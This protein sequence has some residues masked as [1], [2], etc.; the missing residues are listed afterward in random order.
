MVAG[1]SIRERILQAD[2]STR[3][4]IGIFKVAGVSIRERILQDSIPA[5]KEPAKMS[6]GYRSERG[7]CKSITGWSF[8]KVT[9]VAGVSIRERILQG[10]F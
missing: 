10:C 3:V 2:R 7:Y 6:Q 8:C 4:L 9:L 1:V 5:S